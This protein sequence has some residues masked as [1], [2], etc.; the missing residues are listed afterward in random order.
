MGQWPIS[1]LLLCDVLLVLTRVFPV[2]SSFNILDR[3]VVHK[4]HTSRIKSKSWKLKG[5]VENVQDTAKHL[6]TSFYMV[7]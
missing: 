2:F 1:E 7:M 4:M 3:R 6:Y 5:A